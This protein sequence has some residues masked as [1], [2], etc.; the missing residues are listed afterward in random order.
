MNDAVY[1]E[2]TFEELTGLADEDIRNG[3]YIRFLELLTEKRRYRLAVG[4]LA[5]IDT[6]EKRLHLMDDLKIMEGL[7]KMR[8]RARKAGLLLSYG[9]Q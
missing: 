8:Q 6:P 4:F 2:M 7:L 9:G 1:Q 3:W 5:T